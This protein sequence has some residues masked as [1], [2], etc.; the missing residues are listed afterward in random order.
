MVINELD[1]LDFIL[2]KQERYNRNSEK[3]LGLLNNFYHKMYTND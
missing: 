2:I 3:A 1:E